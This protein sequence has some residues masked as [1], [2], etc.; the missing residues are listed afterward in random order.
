M[1]NLAGGWNTLWAAISGAI[2][3]QVMAIMTV[4]GVVLVVFAIGKYFFD[5][6]RGGGVT[7]GLG[8]VMWTLVFGAILAAPQA[9]IPLVLTLLDL[10][11]NSILAIVTATAG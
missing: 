11:I 2:G 4:I 6:R 8:V 3:G 9:I 7:Q 5:K 10:I 1:V